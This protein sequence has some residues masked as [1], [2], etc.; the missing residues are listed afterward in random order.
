MNFQEKGGGGGGD[1]IL[2]IFYFPLIIFRSK[3]VKICHFLIMIRVL[4][5][6]FFVKPFFLAFHIQMGVG[7]TS[8]YKYNHIYITC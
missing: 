2:V 7:H 1:K 5:P 6:K 3:R 8:G 4:D